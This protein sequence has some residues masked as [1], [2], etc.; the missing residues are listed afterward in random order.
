[1]LGNLGQLA[2]LLKNAGQ[3]KENMKEMQGRLAAARYASESGGGQVRATVDGKGELVEI[4]LD[5]AT[6]QTGDTEL[7]EDLICAA[8]RDAVSQSR[9]AVQKEMQAATGGMDLSGMMGDMFGSK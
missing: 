6:V 5:P 8:V 7:L 1:M 4:K 3:I 2:S 9:E